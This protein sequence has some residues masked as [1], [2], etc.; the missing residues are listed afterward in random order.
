MTIV[1]RFSEAACPHCGTTVSAAGQMEGD[2][3]VVE[4]DRPTTGDLTLCPNCM[5]ILSYRVS[6]GHPSL[7]DV[8]EDLP[9]DEEVVAALR[10]A[11]EAL[12]AVRPYRWLV[13]IKENKNNWVFS[14]MGPLPVDQI[15]RR[16]HQAFSSGRAS[17]VAQWVCAPE[18]EQI[19][20]A[21]VDSG[22][23]GLADIGSCV[24]VYLPIFRKAAEG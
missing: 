14:A 8:P 20:A 7:V 18:K 5:Q 21:L 6:D 22:P 16:V 17:H 19:E 4:S 24:E 23:M 2:G 3:R 13:F 10:A 9:V 1:H 11:R 12:L 15:E